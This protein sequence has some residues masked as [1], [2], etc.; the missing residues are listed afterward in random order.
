MIMKNANGKYMMRKLNYFRG[1]IKLRIQR[2][3]IRITFL[4]EIMSIHPKGLVILLSELK[5]QKSDLL[6]KEER[7]EEDHICTE[8]M[9]H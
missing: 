3:T 8:E 9:V 6:L 5:S 2:E 7:R 4:V 1:K